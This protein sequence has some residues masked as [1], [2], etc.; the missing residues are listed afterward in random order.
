MFMFLF[1]FMFMK[2]NYGVRE[3]ALRRKYM[4]FKN[5]YTFSKNIYTFL[6]NICTI[7]KYMLGLCYSPLVRG[8][9][10][11]GRAQGAGYNIKHRSNICFNLK[12]NTV[13]KI[14]FILHNVVDLC[15]SPRP[16]TRLARKGAVRAAHKGR[17]GGKTSP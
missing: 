4:L 15:Y 10:T 16:Y 2:W 5:I 17:R 7:R 3:G 1:I 14:C 12:I 9:R 13:R 11:R 6:K 8:S